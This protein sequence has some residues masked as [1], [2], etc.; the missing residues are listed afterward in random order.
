MTIEFYPI[1]KPRMDK[2]LDSLM[3]AWE[4][5][6]RATHHFLTEQDIQKACSD[7]S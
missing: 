1:D 7:V 5:S 3:N 6:V 4:R 2:L